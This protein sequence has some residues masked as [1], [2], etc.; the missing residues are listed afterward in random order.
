MN[1]LAYTYDDDVVTELIDGVIVA[2]SSPTL[3]H[4]VAVFAITKIFDSYLKGKSCQVIQAFNVNLTK[5][6][7]LVPD[8]LVVCNKEI[9]KDDA[10]YGAPDLVVEVLSPTTEKRDRGYKKKLYEKFG[11][12]EYWLVDTHKRSIEVY[13]NADG[14]LDLHDIYQIY[15]DYVVKNMTDAQ[16][17]AVV[18]EFKTSIFDD[19]MIKVADVFEGVV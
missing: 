8:V 14:V 6:D 10:V 1:G 4:N 9:V 18:D 12:R 3:K 15:P 16:R 13:Y 7:R 11:V 17:D 5:K 2:M 19:L